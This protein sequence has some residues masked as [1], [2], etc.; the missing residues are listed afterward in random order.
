[1][2]SCLVG[3]VTCFRSR[4]RTHCRRQYRHLQTCQFTNIRQ[5]SMSSRHA[6]QSKTLQ[7]VKPT[8]P[9][10]EWPQDLDSSSSL[11]SSHCWTV[12]SLEEMLDKRVNWSSAAFGG[13]GSAMSLSFSPC[14]SS[15]FRCLSDS[16][17]SCMLW[18]FFWCL[19]M[20]ACDDFHRSCSSTR[21]SSVLSSAVD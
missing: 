6:S 2:V 7:A 11:S 9:A 12:D 5:L 17:A 15:V 14:S 20:V 4:R 21:S 8:A 10:S 3:L 1:M 18:T 19:L 13:R 16:R